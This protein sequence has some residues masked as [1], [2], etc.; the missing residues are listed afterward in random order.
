MRNLSWKLIA[1][2][3]ACLCAATACNKP[4]TLDAS[5]LRGL[6][7]EQVRQMRE[8]IL[9]KHEDG[10]SLSKR[11]TAQVE[12]LREQER[13]LENSWIF[14]EWRE[15]HGA[16]L[17]FRDDGTV[18]VGA[19]GGEYDEF[20]VYKFFSPEE[21]SYESF[22]SLFYDEAGDPVAVVSTAS[23]EKL[24]YPFHRSHTEV[25]ERR[26]DLQE[27]SETGCYFVKINN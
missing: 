10:S 12:M 4:K 8:S 6:P 11:E 24:L 7:Q 20:G 1:A 2:F 3:A 17:L 18:S 13:R 26:G 14:G 9:S 19:R 16:R 21:P 27:S 25:R 15:R 23:G 22:W 5:S